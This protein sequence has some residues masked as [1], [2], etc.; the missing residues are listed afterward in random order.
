MKRATGEYQ[1]LYANKFNIL[2]G[3]DKSLKD[4]AKAH[5]RR[6]NLNSFSFIKEIEFV[7]KNFPTK[8][9]PGQMLHW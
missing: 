8:K 2:N 7:V 5:P 1:E 6:N 3:M 4:P 9:T